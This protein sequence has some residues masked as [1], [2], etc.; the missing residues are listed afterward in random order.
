MRFAPNSDAA[1]LDHPRDFRPRRNDQRRLRPTAEA[2]PSAAGRDGIEQR[3]VSAEVHRQPAVA[4][5]KLAGRLRVCELVQTHR[6]G[7]AAVAGLAMRHSAR[8]A[9][10]VDRQ[11][12]L[13]A[14]LAKVASLPP[15]V[16]A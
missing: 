3:I 9:R 7:A 2:D 11:L 12:R 5:L 14:A 8:R 10:A 13:P 4:G 16:A 15:A 1:I 6:N